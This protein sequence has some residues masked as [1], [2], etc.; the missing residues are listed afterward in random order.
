SGR[1][2]WSRG[3]DPGP[4]GEMT[5]TTAARAG[6]A[7]PGGQGAR[8]G[9]LAGIPV[10]ER[11]LSLAGIETSVLEGG[12]GPA[13]LLLHGPGAYGASWQQV[14]PDLVATH[15]VLAPD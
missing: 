9:L 6:R 5:G 4:G 12:D 3:D 1:G 8:E 10:T 14:M 7:Q 2:A 15:H 11:R 13:L